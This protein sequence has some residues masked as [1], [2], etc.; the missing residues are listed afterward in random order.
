MIPLHLLLV[1]RVG[2]KG[3]SLWVELN[4]PS[5]KNGFSPNDS[6]LWHFVFDQTKYNKRDDDYDFS[7][8]IAP[9]IGSL[10][11]IAEIEWGRDE[12]T[13]K[14][15]KAVKFGCQRRIGRRRVITT[16]QSKLLAHFVI[17]LILWSAGQLVNRRIKEWPAILQT[18][19]FK[20]RRSATAAR[21]WKSN[22]QAIV[23]VLA[24]WKHHHLLAL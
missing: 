14:K 12:E 5:T 6:I 21:L 1:G 9:L 2:I 18:L 16:H 13:M 17:E 15:S 7:F 10:W 3:S 24:N 8:I 23:S 20:L 11:L 22:H 4:D 19:Q